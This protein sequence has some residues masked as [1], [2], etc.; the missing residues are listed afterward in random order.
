MENTGGPKSWGSR[1]GRLLATGVR[2]AMGLG[3]RCDAC[4][5][6]VPPHARP[7]RSDSGIAPRHDSSAPLL[8]QHCAALLA[9]RQGGY[10]P[11]CGELYANSDAPPHLCG[12]CLTTP[13]P[14]TNFFFLRGYDDLLR[15]S[16]VNFKFAKRLNQQS[17]IESLAIT[18]FDHH[19]AEYPDMLIP[20]PLHPRRLAWRGYNHS[21]ELCRGLG[22]AIRRPIQPAALERI[23]NTA[24]QARLDREQRRTNLCGAF[25]SSEELVSGRHVLLVDDVATTGATLRECALALHAAS[26]RRVDVLVLARA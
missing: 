5:R 2:C 21:L 19:G 16:I 8:C 10:C 15:R 22:K 18:V 3:L 6:F 20:V 13:P 12:S 14:W 25:R 23:R 24:P 17:L 1:I 11:T 9:P 26:V 7:M 4:G